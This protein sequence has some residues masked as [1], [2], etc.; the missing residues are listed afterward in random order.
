[1]PLTWVNDQKLLFNM[2]RTQN[3]S[4][5]TQ[6]IDQKRRCR[7]GK[8]LE[9]KTN[10]ISGEPPFCNR[11]FPTGQATFKNSE[12]W[13]DL[14]PKIYVRYP[15]AARR[16]WIQVIC[17]LKSKLETRKWIE[18]RTFYFPAGRNGRHCTFLVQLKEP[19]PFTDSKMS[20]KIF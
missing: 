8:S 13:L 11:R 7:G 16:P 4:S 6:S 18:N 12:T 3:V 15:R 14:A 20:P 9:S 1:M 5:P 10:F 17:E 19:V 2:I